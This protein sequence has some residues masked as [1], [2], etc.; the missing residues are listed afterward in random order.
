[1]IN[2]LKSRIRQ[3][4]GG[5][6]STRSQAASKSQ[7]KTSNYE[8]FSHEYFQQP[9]DL[10][11]F[12]WWT[13][14]QMQFEPELVRA[15]EVRA[16]PMI[17]VEFAHRVPDDSER[18][19][20][21]K[22]G[23][24]CNR[25]DVK[26]F[27]DRQLETIRGFMHHLVEAQRDGW[28]AGEVTLKLNPE[29]NQV[30][31]DKLH[32]LGYL[33]CRIM[34]KDGE[35]VGIRVRRVK[36]SGDV[37]LDFPYAYIHNH[38]RP[39]GKRYGRSIL[40]GAYSPWHDKWSEGGA[41]DVRRL[42][43]H[44]DA[45]G[46][47]VL[48]Y[49]GGETY[50]ELLEKEVPNRDIA[51]QI[52]EQTVAG[53]VIVKPSAVDSAGNPEWT[54]EFAKVAS[55]PQ[56]I[57][58]YPKDLDAEMRTGVGVTDGVV[59]NDNSG[60][61]GDTRSIAMQAFYSTLDCWM[62][63]LLSDLGPQIIEHLVKL[64]FGEGV[65]YQLSHK[66]F[67]EQ[68][69]EGQNSTKEQNSNGMGGLDGATGRDGD[70]DGFTGDEDRPDDPDGD[71]GP[72]RTPDG[73]V[74]F[75][76]MGL[77]GEGVL[78]VAD[79]VTA[80]REAVR[81]SLEATKMSAEG[82]RWIT[83]GADKESGKK[84]WPVKI[85]GDGK[86]LSGPFRGKTMR[87]AFDGGEPVDRDSLNE[88]YDDL[89]EYENR[90][91]PEQFEND[92]DGSAAIS[93]D[94]YESDEKDKPGVSRHY[95]RV[96]MFQADAWDMSRDDYKTIADQVWSDQTTIQHDRE[97]AKA[98]A[99]RFTGANSR[100]VSNLEN[101]GKDVGSD[102]RGMDEVGT[103]MMSAFPSLGWTD[104]DDLSAKVW[105]LVRE[106]KQKKWTRTSEAFHDAVDDQINAMSQT[107][108]LPSEWNTASDRPE[109]VIA[110]SLMM[111]LRPGQTKTQNGKTY[112][113]N[114]NHRWESTDK[115]R[116]RQNSLFEKGKG[117]SL[118][119]TSLFDDTDKA[120][121]K[122]FGKSTAKETKARSKDNR[123]FRASK[124]ELSEMAGN[125]DKAAQSEI[126]RRA[127]KRGAVGDKRKVR[128]K[129]I[130]GLLDD[131]EGGD[132][133][134]IDKLRTVDNPNLSG[135]DR[136]RMAALSGTDADVGSKAKPEKKKGDDWHPETEV[137]GDNTAKR[138]QGVATVQGIRDAMN[139][140][141]EEL[142][143]NTYGESE[144]YEV[145]RKNHNAGWG[146]SRGILATFKKA[147]TQ[148]DGTKQKG[149][150]GEDYEPGKDEKPADAEPKPKEG[151]T[152]TFGEFDMKDGDLPGQTSMFDKTDEGPKDGDVNGD[153]LVFRDG[154]WHRDG[155][156]V[157]SAVNKAF[158]G[159]GTPADRAA[160]NIE[161]DR[162][163]GSLDSQIDKGLAKAAR[164]K[165]KRVSDSRHDLNADRS[166][167]RKLYVKVGESL[168]QS[169]KAK[170]GGSIKDIRDTLAVMVD[171]NPKKA[172]EIMESF[173]SSDAPPSDARGQAEWI[174]RRFIKN[175][176]KSSFIPIGATNKTLA[177]KLAK[178]IKSKL[179]S[180]VKSLVQVRRGSMYV[181]LYEGNENGTKEDSNRLIQ[182]YSELVR[183]SI[184]RLGVQN[185]EHG[186]EFSFIVGKSGSVMAADLAKGSTG[187]GGVDF[188]GASPELLGQVATGLQKALGGHP[189][190]KLDGIG[191]HSKPMKS[192][193]MYVQTRRM[194]D[195]MN[196]GDRS[197]VFQKKLMKGKNAEASAVEQQ[198]VWKKNNERSLRLLEGGGPKSEAR[199]RVLNATKRWTFAVE[200]P[201]RYAELV[202]IHEANHAIYYQ[203]ETPDGNVEKTF[204]KQL[205]RLY[206]SREERKLDGY[207]VGEYAGSSGVDEYFTEIACGI[208][209]GADL[210]PR[211]VEA[212]K[213]SIQAAIDHQKGK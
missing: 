117:D 213:K 79:M 188:S 39:A 92:D 19:F 13:I 209:T 196:G 176:D 123:Y 146:T 203:A 135:K 102:T 44:K 59:D 7:K 54:F 11:L 34:L 94:A 84:G 137:T 53:G 152:P 127:D 205:G 134:A 101:K 167:A 156:K 208:E 129:T 189:D 187:S 78:S 175:P 87:E 42:F 73:K 57:L 60:G 27:I 202:A 151:K 75:T 184:K 28:A 192:L 157:R 65:V 119:Q 26:D 181:A 61:L 106:G 109:E 171:S 140:K 139:K 50:D 22:P 160:A 197:I 95:H 174:N 46:G 83:V 168:A 10:P 72:P 143:I 98:F 121:N 136:E 148:S 88:L 71:K 153:G 85:S 103:E 15:L 198:R 49:P 150:F 30:E 177:N 122:L 21:W 89:T 86:M 161:G 118:G 212:Y 31:I 130:R 147:E 38:K 37:D 155:E 56:H 81:M 48:G 43:M 74:D 164:E 5:N 6:G 204:K 105:D 165:K 190:V 178:D 18:G 67:A 32:P 211:M 51:R 62:V 41:L 29:T 154:R 132:Q 20:S 91:Q 145:K 126:D 191:W 33:D 69:L 182:E 100:I 36:Q 133:D 206:D 113:L 115:Q 35:P 183:E 14:Q 58:N 52:A 195:P 179:P 63:E 4:I 45:Y 9:R 199:S 138:W 116:G 131:A 173:Q 207:R 114:R 17:N 99:R 111:S 201:K 25:E 162:G 185:R 97:D 70:G 169:S 128:V 166:K 16:S 47:M 186:D 77:V 141:T 170:H 172:I 82:E 159:N 3:L 107:Y 8:S 68:A 149:M 180:S 55:N 96:I 163:E 193:G 66:P 108:G 1:M 76:A 200:N 112:T 142:V 144:Q 120:D 210:P 80:A 125:G 90:S 104:E 2:S 12:S 64:N 110:M 23:C 93:E 124:T 40:R 194:G 24:K 158:G